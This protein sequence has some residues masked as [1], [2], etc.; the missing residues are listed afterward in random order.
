MDIVRD[1]RKEKA[2][3]CPASRLLLHNDDVQMLSEGEGLQTGCIVYVTGPLCIKYASQTALLQPFW[4][5]SVEFMYKICSICNVKSYGVKN[6]DFCNGYPE[7]DCLFMISNS[8]PSLLEFALQ[9]A[10]LT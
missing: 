5:N 4:V 8:L 6:R 2:H 9:P 1:V 7:V 10:H 3:K